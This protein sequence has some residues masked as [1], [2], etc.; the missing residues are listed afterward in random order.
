[1]IQ[2]LLIFI[3]LASA[4]YFLAFYPLMFSEQARPL[5]E[6]ETVLEFLDFV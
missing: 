2:A 6:F 3:I 5:F 4:H 1:M